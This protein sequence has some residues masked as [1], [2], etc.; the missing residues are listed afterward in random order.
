MPAKKTKWL[1][2]KEIVITYLALS[3]FLYW[4]EIVGGIEQS[5]LGSVAEA[6]GM[7]LLDRDILLIASVIMFFILEKLIMEKF[8]SGN[9]L[10]N[11]TLYAVGFVGMIGLFYGYLW[12]MSWFFEVNFPNLWLF[13]SNIAIGYV[14]AMVFLN[15][16]YYFKDR[17]KAKLEQAVA[18]ECANDKLA[19][20]K[21]L[22]D[23]GILTQE[24]FENKKEKVQAN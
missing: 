21:I 16:K 1:P 6:V 18:E 5:S 19:M 9:M 8:K 4:M 15:A 11:I 20:L 24:E 7:R 17:E 10:K 22:H 23:D 14:V 2:V 13:I 12:G 3:K